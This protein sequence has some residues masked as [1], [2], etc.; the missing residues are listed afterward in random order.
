MKGFDL[1]ITTLRTI[2]NTTTELPLEAI[3]FND[4]DDGLDLIEIPSTDNMENLTTQTDLTTTTYDKIIFP[5]NT[6]TPVSATSTYTSTTTT[7]TTSTT[8]TTLLESTTASTTTVQETSSTTTEFL[9]TLTSGP[10]QSPYSMNEELGLDQTTI[11]IIGAAAVSL[12][13]LCLIVFCLCKCKNQNYKR[14]KGETA[15]I[16]PPS[17]CSS[18]L[19]DRI[20]EEI[21]EDIE[22]DNY[23]EA[24]TPPDIPAVD[25]EVEPS[26]RFNSASTCSKPSSATLPLRSSSSTRSCSESPLPSLS[27]LGRELEWMWDGY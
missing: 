18:S 4:D 12:L 23:N 15:V 19:D 27:P 6:T 13:L 25:A 24:P 2:L 9:R 14:F 3:E 17:K 26:S 16:R 1:I 5:E 20:L 10:V 11:I 7:T 8:T 21:N 22:R